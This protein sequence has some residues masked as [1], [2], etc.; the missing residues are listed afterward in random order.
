MNTIKKYFEGMNMS[1]FILIPDISSYN[2]NY[3]KGLDHDLL[4]AK[5][6]DDNSSTWWLVHGDYSEYL[7]ETDT[8]NSD[9]HLYTNILT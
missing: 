9:T 7:G 5:S 3:Y 2:R 8:S 6:D 1:K 4:F